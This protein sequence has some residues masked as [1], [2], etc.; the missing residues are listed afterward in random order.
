[1]IR[2]KQNIE[3]ADQSINNTIMVCKILKYYISIQNEFKISFNKGPFCV[4]IAC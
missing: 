1:M 3:G 2:W 4:I